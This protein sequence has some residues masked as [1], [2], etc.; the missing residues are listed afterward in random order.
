[1]IDG[2]TTTSACIAPVA[3]PSL[4]ALVTDILYTQLGSGPVTSDSLFS[5]SDTT[6]KY[7]YIDSFMYVAGA[8]TGAST[9]VPLR[10]IKKA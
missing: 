2:P 5:D 1:M 3:Q 7:Y 9:Q 10:L 8:D 6:T 4:Q